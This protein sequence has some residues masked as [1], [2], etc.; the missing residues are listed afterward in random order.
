MRS[1][2]HDAACIARPAPSRTSCC[3][4]PQVL[5]L[6]CEKPKVEILK[7]SAVYSSKYIAPVQYQTK[8]R[9][10]IWGVCCDDEQHT[11]GA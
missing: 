10:W 2:P 3:V 1:T 9:R 4:P 11:H 5:S 7:L 8:V 6:A